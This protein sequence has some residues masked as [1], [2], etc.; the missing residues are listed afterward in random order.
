T[1][2]GLGLTVF[3]IVS[4]FTQAPMGF[5]VDRFG[6]CRILIIG[7]L[8]ESVAFGV[9]G[10]A[11]VYGIFLFLLGIA[12]I[13]NSV[14]HPADYVILNNI[15]PDNR[16]GRAFSYHTS[17][18]LVGEAIAPATILLLAS[19]IDWRIALALCGSL[20]ILTGF[21]LMMNT[22]FLN[23]DLSRQRNETARTK[24]GAKILF[25]TPILMGVLFFIGVSIVNRGITGFSVSA[26]HEGNEL[27]LGVAGTLL[28][29]WLFASPLGVLL[30]GRIADRSR[31]HTR[32]I[33]LCFTLIGGCIFGIVTFSANIWLCS[34]F[35][36]F[37]GFFAGIVSP[38]RDMLIRSLTP[39]GQYGKVFGFVST[40]FN[41]GGIVA[42]PIY[43]YV[44]DH[45]NP[46]FVFWIAALAS[47]LT[48]FTVLG[49]NRLYHRKV[50]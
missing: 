45:S 50:S 35:F 8:I 38:S 31:H 11:P 28:S 5:L 1:E 19:I 20:G 26:L 21:G 12:G 10:V 18:G 3:S 44:L 33:A 49:S 14:Y 39:P 27:S 22:R 13:A 7:I 36:A 16:I 15:V 37:G 17:A 46:D 47:F 6:P 29:A 43:G 23:D 42:P 32:N 2:I 41:I 25:T 48:I 30:G 40:G 34:M 9:I 4:G 24:S